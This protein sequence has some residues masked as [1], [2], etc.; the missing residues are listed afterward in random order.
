MRTR[1]AAWIVPAIALSVIAL[2]LPAGVTAQTPTGGQT[3]PAESAAQAPDSV[4][5]QP[6]DSIQAQPAGEPTATPPPATAPAAGAAG[7]TATTPQQAAP[8]TTPPAQAPPSTAPPAT[9]PAAPSAQ[10]AQPPPAAQSSA[11]AGRKEPFTKGTT[12]V[13]ITGGWGRSF[14]EDYLMLGIGAGRF[15]ANGLNIGLD[16]EAWMLGDPGVFKI[17]PAV[18]YVLSGPQR[19]TKPYVGGFWRRTMIEDAE[20]LSSVGGRAGAYF[21]GAGPVMIGGGAV[22]ENYLDCDENLYQ[23]CSQVYPEFLISAS[24]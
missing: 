18:N 21:K 20:D 17:S 6:P 16:V 9:A 14:D 1:T 19:R 23:N 11:P 10:S 8:S 22:W 2:A 24:F 15:I 4:Q 5:A 12:R 13:S 7:T 3:V